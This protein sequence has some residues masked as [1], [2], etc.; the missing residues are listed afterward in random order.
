MN[1]RA[2]DRS[3]ICRS[4]VARQRSA[5]RRRVRFFVSHQRD[6][7][8]RGLNS[9]ALRGF[10]VLDQGSNQRPR[11][12]RYR[13][14]TSTTPGTAGLATTPAAVLELILVET[15]RLVIFGAGFTVWYCRLAP[16]GELV[17]AG[18]VTL[19]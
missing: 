16:G 19:E 7:G 6:L 4:Y 3:A 13:R 10:G 1:L 5:R 15:E 12:V 2:N 9:P 17:A 11:P 8:N 14:K 18:R